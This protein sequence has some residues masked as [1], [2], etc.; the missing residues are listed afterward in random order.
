MY[1]LKVPRNLAI[2]II[3]SLIDVLEN[4]GTLTF[5]YTTPDLET[6]A[7]GLDR[8]AYTALT[9]L[10]E[11]TAGRIDGLYMNIFGHQFALTPSD[12]IW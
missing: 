2:D 6:S 12:L 1:M 7:I 4:T 10:P 5:A 8:Q 9:K 11:G 3:H